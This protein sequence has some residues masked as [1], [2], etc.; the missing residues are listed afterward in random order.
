MRTI[1]FNNSGYVGIIRTSDNICSAYGN[2]TF[3]VEF[4]ANTTI[5]SNATIEVEGTILS[6]TLP[7]RNSK[8]LF[9]LNWFRYYAPSHGIEPLELSLYA[10]DVLVAS[11]EYQLTAGRG[12]VEFGTPVNGPEL[13]FVNNEVRFVSDIVVWAPT[14]CTKHWQNFEFIVFNCQS[15]NGYL[16]KGDFDDPSADDFIDK[17]GFMS[18]KTNPEW[19]EV[20]SFQNQGKFV[21][22]AKIPTPDATCADIELRITNRHGLRGAIGGKLIDASEGGDDIKTNF[23][24]VTPYAGIYEWSKKGAT[25]KK[26]VGFNF[27]GDEGLLSLLRD[28][29]VYGRVEWYDERTEQ[30]LPCRIEEKTI[31][32]NAWD[33]Q[34]VTIVLQ[35]L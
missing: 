32:N 2:N 27:E 22:F 7:V 8:A 17:V 31:G 1:P 14:Q 24:K 4:R 26:E 23:N 15:H 3:E 21:T 10:N 12:E 9:S 18:E 33:E 11:V 35:E 5:A 19:G 25:I 29:C 28:G 6:F 34:I 30:W 20:F 16:W 13:G